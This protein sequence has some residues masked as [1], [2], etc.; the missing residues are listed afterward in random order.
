[1]SYYKAATGL[2]KGLSGIP[3]FIWLLGIFWIFFS[4]HKKK[5]KYSYP[6]GQ[7]P[8]ITKEQASAYASSLHESMRYL[9]TDEDRILSVIDSLS[10]SDY[11]LVHNSFGKRKYANFGGDIGFEKDLTTWFKEELSS[12]TDRSLWNKI[13]DLSNSAGIPF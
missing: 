8:T 9:G 7:P 1:M 11:V 6:E 5:N 13:K 3:W 4:K 10:P 12:I 2:S